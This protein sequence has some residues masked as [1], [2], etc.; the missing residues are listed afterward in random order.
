MRKALVLS[1]LLGSVSIADEL[2]YGFGGFE[3]YKLEWQT[4]G[5]RSA[6]VDGDGLMDLLFA[7][8]RKAKIEVM[9]RRKDPVPLETKGG[10]KLPNELADDR[11][12]E[13]R[14]ILTEKEVFGIVAT[15]L[16]SDG[17]VD[18]AYFGRPEEL[19]IAYGD[20]KGGFP[21]T[22]SLAVDGGALLR[23]G[24]AAGDLN[25]DGKTDLALVGKGYT[26]VY[27]QSAEG[28]F[29]EPQKLP[30]SDKGV[31]VV[32]IVD[33]EGDGRND[34]VHL[35][36]S[37][38]RSV[39]VRFGQA[40][41][42]LGPVVSLK[43]TPWRIGGFTE[44]DGKPGAELVVVQRSSG[45]MRVLSVEKSSGGAARPLGMGAP[46]I[47]A[48][49]NTGGK[50]S[51]ALAIGDVNGDG[52]NDV[53]VTEPDTAQVALYLQ[54]EDGRLRARRTFPSLAGAE[55][56]RVVDL[57]GDK[58]AEVIVMS[59]DEG[60]VGIASLTEEGRLP[61]PTTIKIPGKPLAMDAG[62]VRSAE[63]A[64]LLVI[65]EG[66][67]KA[68]VAL[69]YGSGDIAPTMKIDLPG[70]KSGPDGVVIAQMDHLGGTD[71]ILLDRFGPAQV[72]RSQ[73]DGQGVRSYI[74]P[75]GGRKSGGMLNRV[76][77]ASLSLGD[78]D[79]SG[80]SELLVASKN[81]ARAVRLDKD[82]AMQ[83]V[84]QANGRSP[85]ASI[86][87]AVAA[88]FDADGKNDVA[89]FDRTG[90]VVTML[91]RDATGALKVVGSVAVG[92]LDF[93]GM[94]AAD[95]NGDG[96]TDLVIAGRSRFAVLYAGGAN[97]ELVERHTFERKERF[98][99]LG[100]SAMGDLNGDKQPDLA[101]IDNGTRSLVV[102]SVDAKHGM[103]ERLAWRVYEK[104]MHEAE[105]RSG[106][107]REVVVAD[108]NGDG[109]AD[110]AILVHDRLLVYT[111]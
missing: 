44:L 13:K 3:I 91:Q 29:G 46:S 98:T 102:L 110:I 52:R 99:Q 7:N 64:D 84:D 4:R 71:L 9:L 75:P 94:R 61:F 74:P 100:Y 39:R 97:L 58:R 66:E 15:D 16:N 55:T 56:L 33:V 77:A 93:R 72:W 6:D 28:T 59:K 21:R 32:Q 60:A 106:G 80:V 14:E 87:G 18:V 37:S 11:F 68:R 96:R 107:A 50:K 8:N 62:P 35:V 30:H 76:D 89:L 105:E 42:S 19:V 12:F 38:P 40:D 108:F 23:R 43:T 20:G 34:L 51:R 45:V 85:R 31:A 53:V 65:A 5:L 17:K 73:V 95:M 90:N 27:S 69:V 78:I 25:G 81:F 22:A 103:R 104:K 26:A 41:G 2:P 67:K 79:G 48:F 63:K 86:K 111:Q 82:G 109:A 1:L 92:T 54:G 10:K 24:L 70:I 83:V 47:H 36:P 57:N 101:V 49:E 88:D